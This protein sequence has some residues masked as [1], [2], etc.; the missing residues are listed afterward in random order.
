[1]IFVNYNNAKFGFRTVRHGVPQ[2]SILGPILFSIYIND[3]LNS[4]DTSLS[5][6]NKILFDL[7]I[8]SLR[9][10]EPLMNGLPLISF[11]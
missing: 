2:G 9:L 6:R 5:V 8:K 10:K 1:M 11:V 4:L 7:I 3:L